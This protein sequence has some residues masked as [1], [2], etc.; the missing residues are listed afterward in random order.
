MIRVLSIA[1]GVWACSCPDTPKGE[2][3][4]TTEKAETKRPRTLA[5]RHDHD[6]EGFDASKPLP[7]SS[8]EKPDIILVSIDTLRPDHLGTYGYSRD[9]SPF[10]DSLAETGTVFEQA[11]SPSPW[12][13]PS[14]TTMLTGSLPQ[15]HG[16]IEDHSSIPTKLPIL[17]GH[18]KKHGYQTMGAV[19]TMFVSS[20]FGFDRKFDHFQDFGVKD[21]RTN[22]LSTV[23]ADHV[24]N[25]GLHWAQQ[26]PAD[27][28]L[29]LFLHVY[30]VH[31]NYDPPPPWNE[32]F[33]RAP[34]HSDVPY[35]NYFVYK[36]KPLDADQM[37]HQIAQ[38]DEEIAF[39]DDELRKLVGA[40]RKAG[41]NVIVA[42][43]A[44]HGEEFG[45]R[46]SW[47]HGHTVWPE[48]LRVPL[49]ING[50]GVATQ[51]SKHRIGT[52]DIAP[53]LAGLIGH[54]FRVH[55]GENRSGEV[56]GKK[57]KPP[58]DRIV[59]ELGSTSRFDSLVYRWHD[60]PFDLVV[61]V[62]RR[63]RSLCNTVRDPD[64]ASNI[65]KTRPAVGQRLYGDMVAFMGEP[66]EVQRNGK[67]DVAGGRILIDGERQKETTIDVK[68]G[69]KLTILPADAFV[70]FEGAN[71]KK[72]GPW[73]A[74][75]GTI[76][77]QGC[78]LAFNKNQLAA[79]PV[80]L[81]ST[82]RDQ[83]KAL[84]YVQAE[85]EDEAATI[86]RVDCK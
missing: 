69:D 37:F 33:D 78:P 22:G 74:V 65:Y 32:K 12:T 75:G 19:A 52:E 56:K 41:R 77:G 23:D 67:V 83:L 85:D 11:F 50:P 20:K 71:G 36:N 9:T 84:G 29:F 39:V 14:H 63:H 72:F 4:P 40:W 45:E 17:Q 81:S 68:R 10:I 3:A 13:L 86:G 54:P 51:R 42:V 27:T 34:I 43:T 79:K 31:Y 61:D 24:F 48:Q 57:A 35:R 18:L 2:D 16:A 82:E 49:V 6:P 53:T 66:W 59:A 58:A 73:R 25:H 55:D 30:D 70:G 8:N 15:H 21:K 38:Y 28:P 5:V 1:V 76:P 46:G 62:K 26:Q 64:C 47:G 80:S 7:P 44:D 60:A